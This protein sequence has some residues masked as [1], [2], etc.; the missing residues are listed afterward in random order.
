[1]SGSKAFKIL[2]YE[3]CVET[4]A[5]YSIPLA[6]GKIANSPEEAVKIAENIGYPIALKVISPQII[7]KT[8]AKILKLGIRSESELTNAYDEIIRN[9]KQY[10]PNAEIRGVLVQKMIGGVAEVV[11]GISRD[12]QFG[13]VILFG[14]GGIFVE[15]F[16]DVSLRVPPITRYDAEEMIREIKGYKIL[17]GFRGRPKADIE[18]IID[19]LFKVSN[20][21]LD[22]KESILEMDLNPIIVREEGNGACVV[23]VRMIFREAGIYE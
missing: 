20:L 8:D 15:V 4:L 14:L 12:V 18:A 10:N 5:R 7:H 22:L 3:Q 17:E 1:L 2:P 13:P 11:V 19:I 16:R 9:A 21:A 6:E 23:D